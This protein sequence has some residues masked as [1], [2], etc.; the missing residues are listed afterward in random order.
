MAEKIIAYCGII[1]NECPAFVATKENNNDKRKKTA[2]EWSKEFNTT[3]TAEEI[4]CTGCNV[5]GP[6]FT[7]CKETCEIRKCG[8]E[9][10]I[11]NCA[12]CDQYACEKLKGF[13]KMVPGCEETLNK[14][15]G[16]R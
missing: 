3:M 9:K 1:C 13:F 7:H 16:Q 5:P 10:E 15:Y 11:Q 14:I 4:N 12:Y 2:E 8:L 6:K